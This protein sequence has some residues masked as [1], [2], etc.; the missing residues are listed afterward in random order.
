MTQVDV[1]SLPFDKAISY[2]RQKVPLPTTSWN[3]LW[4]E[5]QDQA[6]TIAA[7]TSADILRDAYEFIQQAIEEGTTYSQFKDGF[8]DSMARNGWV[9]NEHRQP[10]RMELIFGQNIR[11]AYSA[12]RAKQI[13]DPAIQEK[14]PYLQ[15]VHRDSRQPR[16]AHLAIDGLI[17]RSD[18]PFWKN[19]LPTNGFNCK[20]AVFTLSQ[21]ELE[22][23][24][25]KVGE[26]PEEKFSFKD[27]LT[28]KTHTVPAINV[29]DKVIPLAEPGFH[30]I[31]GQTT[32]QE[33]LDYIR[34]R[35]NKFP[36]PLK[37]LVLS[38]LKKH[39]INFIENT[40]NL[41]DIS[42]FSQTILNT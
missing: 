23:E 31:P 10:W 20:C 9:N 39:N 36:P 40:P 35:V 38:Q 26:A 13:F 27:K 4:A 17:L 25:L 19:C 3:Q 24:G 21:E 41:N 18:D 11:N 34:E 33:R 32:E 30:N 12:G 6:F 16:P 22:A 5:A 1:T 37:K 8:I 29:E 7:L 28:G 15:Y 14:R 2:F 42:S